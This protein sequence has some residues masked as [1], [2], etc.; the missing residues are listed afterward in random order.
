[1]NVVHSILSKH[2]GI[3]DYT[4]SQPAFPIIVY[5]GAQLFCRLLPNDP[6]YPQIAGVVFQDFQLDRVPHQPD[7]LFDGERWENWW[8]H[9]DKTGLIRDSQPKLS[10]DIYKW[11]RRIYS[12][13]KVPNSIH[14]PQNSN[15]PM[16]V[17]YSET[18]ILLIH[19]CDGVQFN[20]DTTR[21]VGLLGVP[22]V[23][24]CLD[25]GMFGR[26][27]SSSSVC[28]SDGSPSLQPLPTGTRIHRH[29]GVN[30]ENH[31]PVW[32][33]EEH[34]ERAHLLWNAARF[35][36]SGDNSHGSDDALDG[37]GNAQVPAQ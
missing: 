21:H 12:H 14:P 35:R 4:T 33:E 20:G 25:E 32:V 18:S 28:S 9:W 10:L 30:L 2:N 5:K 26:G 34:A 7:Q 31:I 29:A 16:L 6:I 17:S 8:R 11:P 22:D 36:D 24:Q 23:D 37:M 13:P 15:R 19:D 27:M 3:R 1:M